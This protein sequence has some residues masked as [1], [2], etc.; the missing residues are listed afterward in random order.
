M[1][2]TRIPETLMMLTANSPGEVRRLW[3]I[4]SKMKT[5][6]TPPSIENVRPHA[7]IWKGQNRVTRV[8]DST[9]RPP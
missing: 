5:V 8:H 3:E 7:V 1:D 2:E 9:V 4:G 6:Y